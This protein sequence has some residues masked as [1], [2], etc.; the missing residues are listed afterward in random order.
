MCTHPPKYTYIRLKHEVDFFWA[1]IVTKGDPEDA[2][3][4][5]PVSLT[6]V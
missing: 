6:S 5:R 2:A 4:Y 1:K 3:N